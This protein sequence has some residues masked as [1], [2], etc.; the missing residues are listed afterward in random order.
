[1][2]VEER[3]FGTSRVRFTVHGPPSGESIAY[4][5]TAS[6]KGEPVKGDHGQPLEAIAGTA[7]EAFSRMC[8]VLA[9]RLGPERQP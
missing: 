9:P 4:T 2:W 1:M 3:Y 8:K 5:A 7:E 6:I